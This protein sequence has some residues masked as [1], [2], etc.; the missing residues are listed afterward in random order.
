MLSLLTAALVAS[1][2]SVQ[3]AQD[4]NAAAEDIARNMEEAPET[5][6]GWANGLVASLQDVAEIAAQGAPVEIAEP[7]ALSSDLSAIMT[8]IWPILQSGDGEQGEFGL[9]FDL[10]TYAE[11]EQRSGDQICPSGDGTAF[12]GPF[13]DAGPG[14]TVRVCRGFEEGDE[15]TFYGQAIVLTNGMRE[16]VFIFTLLSQNEENGQIV[17]DAGAAMVERMA[18]SVRFPG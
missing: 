17:A 6:E 15:G 4:P 13:E 3:E 8:E 18:S 14:T 11:G 5:P 9:S 2:L 12:E 10:H 7:E 16:G 1:T